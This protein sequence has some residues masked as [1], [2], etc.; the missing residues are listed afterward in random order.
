MRVTGS[1]SSVAYGISTFHPFTDH[2]CRGAVR[3]ARAGIR[4]PSE[5]LPGDIEGKGG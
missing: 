1:S 5:S 2:A 3:H 4:V